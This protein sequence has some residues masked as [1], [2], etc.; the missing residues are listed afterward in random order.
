MDGGENEWG[1]ISESRC[2]EGEPM[3]GIKQ[4]CYNIE[5]SIITMATGM[6]PPIVMVTLSDFD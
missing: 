2:T 4:M 5:L 6:T 3:G 1:S